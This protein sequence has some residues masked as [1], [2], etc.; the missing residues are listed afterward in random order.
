MIGICMGRLFK[1]A[2]SIQVEHYR[3]ERQIVKTPRPDGNGNQDSKSYIF[4][5]ASTSAP[6]KTKPE[7]KPMRPLAEVAPPYPATFREPGGGMLVSFQ[8]KQLV[9]PC[10]SPSKERKTGTDC[11]RV[12]AV[13]LDPGGHSNPSKETKCQRIPVFPGE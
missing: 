4:S 11:G 12:G 5:S 3:V 6:E 7:L 10:V 13:C 9:E 2:D 1:E 8:K